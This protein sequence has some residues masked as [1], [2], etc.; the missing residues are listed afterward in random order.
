MLEGLAPAEDTYF[1][2]SMPLEVCK[3]RRAKRLRICQETEETRP[4][5]G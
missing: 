3:L 1:V 4:D 5:F 2:D